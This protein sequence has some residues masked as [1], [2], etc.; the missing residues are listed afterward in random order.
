MNKPDGAGRVE[1]LSGFARQKDKRP[2]HRLLE[3]HPE[4]EGAT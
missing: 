1:K 3:K 2:K 4:L